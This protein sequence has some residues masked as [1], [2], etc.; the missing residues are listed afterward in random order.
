MVVVSWSI[1]C[2]THMSSLCCLA[3]GGK[4]GGGELHQK[5][6]LVVE[7]RRSRCIVVLAGIGIDVV[8]VVWGAEFPPYNMAQRA[9]FRV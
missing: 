8:V 7:G 2:T 9:L 1:V 3:L 5:R 6:A 4:G